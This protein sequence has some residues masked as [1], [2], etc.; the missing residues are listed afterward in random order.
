MIAGLNKFKIDWIEKSFQLAFFILRNRKNAL[1]TVK[2]SLDKFDLQRKKERR[3][4]YWRKKHL[5]LWVT[6]VS[7]KDSDILQWLTYVEANP[8]EKQ[9]EDA[10]E[11]TAEILVIRFI[12]SLVEITTALSSFYLNVGLQRILRSYDTSETQRLYEIVTDRHLSAN[13]YRRAKAFLMTKLQERFGSL[14]Q[15]VDVRFGEIRFAAVQQQDLWTVMVDECLQE[16][17]P[18]STQGACL[19]PPEFHSVHHVLPTLL[20]GAGARKAAYD[21]IETNR[22]HAF[23]DPIC[24]RRLTNAVGV[25]SPEQRLSVPEFFLRN[26]NENQKPGGK[27]PDAPP[28]NA[29]ERAEIRQ[30]LAERDLRRRSAASRV[31]RITVDGAERLRVNLD[32]DREQQ[33]EIEEGARTI[34]VWTE[35]SGEEL[36]L[37]CHRI[38]YTPEQGFSLFDEPICLYG[39][40]QLH[41]R[42]LPQPKAGTELS[43]ATV[44]FALRQEVSISSSRSWRAPSWLMLLPKYAFLG[45]VFLA[46]GWWMA[47]GWHHHQQALQQA[48][49]ESLERELASERAQHLAGQ[50]QAVPR[51]PGAIDYRL[52]PDSLASRDEANATL[53]KVPLPQQPAMI[54]FGLTI[55]S[56]GARQYRAILRPFL[57]HNEILAETLP[58]P[59]EA[60]KSLTLKFLVPSSLLSPGRDYTIDL[61]YRTPGG[62]AQE[63]DAFSFET[64]KNE[65]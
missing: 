6:K 21:L 44:T 22:I 26:K 46:L 8:Y 1:E 61:T 31:L 51:A 18:W 13:E 54:T 60:T 53:V 10:G 56:H 65:K 58:Q 27:G 38:C 62:Q 57:E 39:T 9:Q 33:F 64:E 23:L 40:K 43:R 28:L 7:K 42:I 55:A 12:K 2:R 11:I 63:G 3:R 32:D 45:A 37:A 16:F 30:Y 52:L 25:D 17:T 36:V 5:R 4:S 59:E 49:V 15:T 19:I 29:A 47:A 41:L 24:F 34:E 14:L 20:S 35:Y 48:A 50:N